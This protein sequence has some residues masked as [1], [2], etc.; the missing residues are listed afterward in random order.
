MQSRKG[1]RPSPLLSVHNSIFSVTHGLRDIQL[2]PILQALT[3]GAGDIVS[4]SVVLFALLVTFCP[5]SMFFFAQTNMTHCCGG[6]Y[7]C[8]FIYIIFR[9]LC[10]AIM[11]PGARQL[12]CEGKWRK[13]ANYFDLKCANTFREENQLQS[14]LR[15][16]KF[17]LTST[18]SY[19]SI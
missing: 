7:H 2:V 6:S 12:I 11:V 16:C 3:T 10:L 5:H 19:L 8:L 1:T 17:F 14:N 4:L 15:V 18:L 9:I 13:S